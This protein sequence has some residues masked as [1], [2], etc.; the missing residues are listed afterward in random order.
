LKAV[1]MHGY[2]GVEQ[3]CFED[4]D[5]PKLSEPNEII[6]NLKAASINH[7]DIWNRMGATGINVAMPH[8]L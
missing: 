6:V 5:E 2:G 1:R 7:I 8:T 4:A 3:L